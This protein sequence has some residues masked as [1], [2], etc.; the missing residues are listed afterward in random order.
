[1][2]KLLD[3]L[4]EREKTH[5]DFEMKAI[6]IQEIMENISGLY[7]WKNMSADQKEAIH[8][9]LVKLSRIIYGDAN[10]IDHWDDI[11]GYAELVAERLKDSR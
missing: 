5:G 4:E 2:G 3:I 6:F 7:D 1:M 8:M 10:H 9:I 11:A